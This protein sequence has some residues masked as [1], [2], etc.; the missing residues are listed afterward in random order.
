MAFCEAVGVGNEPQRSD[1][2]ITE[3]SVEP[4]VRFKEIIWGG[5]EKARF[6]A[7]GTWI[8]IMAPAL[9]L[10]AALGRDVDLSGLFIC[11]L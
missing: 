3:T 2:E 4:A 8:R 1:R 7:R 6:G 11:L 10:S 5:A 9:T